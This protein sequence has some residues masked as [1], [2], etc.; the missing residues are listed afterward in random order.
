MLERNGLENPYTGVLK[1]LYS[2]KNNYVPYLYIIYCFY[3]GHKDTFSAT[4]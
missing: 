3:F 4:I 1:M 2:L